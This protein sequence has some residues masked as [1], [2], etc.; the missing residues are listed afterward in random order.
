MTPS[1]PAE[2]ELLQDLKIANS[3]LQS[4]EADVW[5]F[6]EQNP[7]KE[8]KDPEYF[9]KHR[10]LTTEIDR[11]VSQLIANHAERNKV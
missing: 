11:L 10:E 8:F 3:K 2:A 1:D 6:F 4:L 9:N 5:T 7:G